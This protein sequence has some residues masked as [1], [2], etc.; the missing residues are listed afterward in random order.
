MA[1]I[2][3]VILMTALGT[4]YFCKKK[5]ERKRALLCKVLA[6]AVPGILMLCCS[7]KGSFDG[8][9]AAGFAGTLAAVVFY[10]AADVLLECKF[11]LGAVSFAAGHVCMTAGFLLSGET[12]LYV[13]ENG[14]YR[15]DAALFTWGVIVFAVLTAAACIALHKYFQPL[16]KK[17]LFWP[18]AA[19]IIVLGV[20]AAL[21]VTAGMRI[22]AAGAD[23][24]DN[25]FRGAIPAA[26]GICFVIS[27][28]LLGRNRLGKR[29]S[30]VCGALVLVLYYL[31]VYLFAMR[32]W[33]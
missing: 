18:L 31:S 3:G 8:I 28:I 30:V 15:I 7:G 17:K 1:G 23:T 9:S 22:W 25:V 12:V 4:Y 13:T 11:I 29:R 33:L 20:M 24:M 6:T 19:Y 26:G 2:L 32:F 16:R 14:E 10:M 5:T 27:D 21:A